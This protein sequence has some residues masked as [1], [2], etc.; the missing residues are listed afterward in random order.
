VLKGRL[1][2]ASIAV[3]TTLEEITKAAERIGVRWG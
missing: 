2:A 3:A 1:G